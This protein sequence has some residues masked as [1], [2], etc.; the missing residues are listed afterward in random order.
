MDTSAGANKG[1]LPLIAALTDIKNKFGTSLADVFTLS[2]V[3]AVQAVSGPPIAWRPGRVDLLSTSPQCG[4]VNADARLPHPTNDAFNTAA[5]PLADGDLANAN[6]PHTAP[7]SSPAT[8]DPKLIRDKFNAMGFFDPN[9]IVALI[10]AHTVGFAHPP[11]SGFF[12]PWTRQPFL[13]SNEFFTS[14]AEAPS[15][16]KFDAGWPSNRL[17]TGVTQFRRS[18]FRPALHGNEP[19]VLFPNAVTGANTVLAPSA[20]YMRL[21]TDC[22]CATEKCLIPAFLY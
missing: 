15:A 16:Q 14:F 20:K 11:T 10:G 3:V 21:P 5:S 1:F 9:Q 18:D 7:S 17:N 13:F 2:A 22:T 6:N 12:G 8:F 4:G 19:D